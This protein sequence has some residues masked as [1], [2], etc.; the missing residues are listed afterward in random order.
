M[1]FELIGVVRNNGD[2]TTGAGLDPFTG[3]PLASA[4]ADTAGQAVVVTAITDEE[5]YG[6][7]IDGGDDD[8]TEDYYGPHDANPNV[9]AEPGDAMCVIY[10]IVSPPHPSALL[11][12]GVTHSHSGSGAHKDWRLRNLPLLPN[13]MMQ[14]GFAFMVNLLANETACHTIN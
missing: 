3:A 5:M 11:L 7:K 4:S 2:S 9:L 14:R 10:C 1:L 12:L 6:K 8:E 13:L